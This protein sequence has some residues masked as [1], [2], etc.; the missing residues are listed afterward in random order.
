MVIDTNMYW[1]PE[2]VFSNDGLMQQFI[3]EIPQGTE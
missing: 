2:E 3:S 1:F